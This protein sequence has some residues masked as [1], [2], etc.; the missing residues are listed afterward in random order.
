MEEFGGILWN[1]WNTSE[2]FGR[3][4]QAKTER[5]VKVVELIRDKR[6]NGK[7][8]EFQKNGGIEIA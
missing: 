5:T 7:Y 8:T 4:D 3:F 6:Y 1:I 2:Y